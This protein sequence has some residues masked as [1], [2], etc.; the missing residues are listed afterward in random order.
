MY[1]YRLGHGDQVGS[2]PTGE[3]SIRSAGAKNYIRQGMVTEKGN[4]SA[5]LLRVVEVPTLIWFAS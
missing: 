3:R 2:N 4:G 1:T 5:M